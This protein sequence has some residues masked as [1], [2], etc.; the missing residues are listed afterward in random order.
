MPGLVGRH[1]LAYVACAEHTSVRHGRIS[2]GVRQRLHHVDWIKRHI[3]LTPRSPRYQTEPTDAVLQLDIQQ[4][5]LTLRVGIVSE[6]CRVI[7]ITGAL[8]VFVGIGG[9]WMM[10]AM[11]T[12]VS[13]VVADAPQLKPSGACLPHPSM[14][15]IISHCY[16]L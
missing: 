1:V 5:V 11:S 12:G 2:D 6:A 3:F 10:R 14:V 8:G 4:P 9:L 15:Y 13:V 7:C 16:D